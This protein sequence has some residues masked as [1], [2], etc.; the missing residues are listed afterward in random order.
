MLPSTVNARIAF[1]NDEWKHRDDLARIY[2]RETRH[3]NTTKHDIEIKNA[4]PLAQAGELDL[5][6]NGFTL[7]RHEAKFTDF[8]DRAAIE[9]DYFSEM[10]D[11]ILSL[12]GAEDAVAFPFYQLRS[13]RPANFFDAYSLY[14]HCDFALT[15]WQAMAQQIV[16]D[17]GNGRQYPAEEWDFALYNLWRPIYETTLQSPLTIVDAATVD[18][19]DIIEYRL[20]PTGETSKA[21]LPVFN[22]RQQLYY[23]PQMRTDEVLVFKQQDSRDGVARVCPHTAFIDPTAPGD[24]PDRRSIDIRMLCVYPR[25]A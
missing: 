24:A 16:R 14:M 13:R 18:L 11:F 12:T 25:G 23:F 1:L 8:E 19:D 17:H 3:A 6:H 21:A 22:P 7:V 4:R 10:R 15:T 20:A 9:R 5:D 2:S